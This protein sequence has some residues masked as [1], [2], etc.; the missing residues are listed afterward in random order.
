MVDNKE[1]MMASHLVMADSKH[2]HTEVLQLLP[3]GYAVMKGGACTKHVTVTS[4]ATMDN[5]RC[6][7]TTLGGHAYET[8]LRVSTNRA[9]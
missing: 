5:E 8:E 4:V 3:D 1:A 6:L 2:T 9:K 7:L